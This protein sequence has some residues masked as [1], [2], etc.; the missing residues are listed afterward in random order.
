MTARALVE[1]IERELPAQ[2]GVPEIGY[3]YEGD[4]EATP[5]TLILERETLRISYDLIQVMARTPGEEEDIKVGVIVMR[6]PDGELLWDPIFVHGKLRMVFGF[7]PDAAR[8]TVASLFRY[9]DTIT[10]G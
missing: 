7:V 4:H 6:A 2:S 10:V 5:V 3:G 1:S 9:N 8:R